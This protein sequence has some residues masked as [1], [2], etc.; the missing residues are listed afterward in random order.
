ME[1][2]LG[3]ASSIIAIIDFS[4]KIINYAQAVESAE[5]DKQRLICELQQI[6][7][8]VERLRQRDI[9]AEGEKMNLLE[10][11]IKE[12]EQLLKGLANNLPANAN[13]M[14]SRLVWPFKQKEIDGTLQAIERYKS[15][16][17][18]VLG[19]HQM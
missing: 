10:Q 1:V 18:V 15:S 8:I 9:R 4:R 11:P 2:G 12:L 16:I 7:D 3:I 14:G 17:T 6:K 13:T 5:I 19:D